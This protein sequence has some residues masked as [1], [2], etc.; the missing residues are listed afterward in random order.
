MIGRSKRLLCPDVTATTATRTP[1]ASLCASLKGSGK[2][3]VF[4]GMH[5]VSKKGNGVEK[6][7]NQ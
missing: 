6:D 1:D 2:K 4:P 7:G 5:M 3:A